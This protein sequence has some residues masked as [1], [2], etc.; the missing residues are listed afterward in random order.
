MG[1]GINIFKLFERW[2]DLLIRNKMA[3][4]ALC[5]AG[6]AIGFSLIQATRVTP[7]PYDSGV[8]DVGILTVEAF[9]VLFFVTSS[10]FCVIWVQFTRSQTQ[11]GS[12][13]NR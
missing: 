2:F 8:G 1:T 4:P 11:R 7:S 10:V 13:D 3:G 6:I 12:R 9:S 5:V